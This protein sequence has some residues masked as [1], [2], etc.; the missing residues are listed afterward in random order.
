MREVDRLMTEELGVPLER[1]FLLG[2]DAGGRRIIMV[3]AGPGGNGAGGLVAARH[4][5][6]AGAEVEVRLAAPLERFAPVTADQA[7]VVQRLGL[8][9][10][11]G[12][13]SL[14]REPELVIDAL[15]GYSQAGAP[16]GDAARLIE[17][18]AG[19]RVLALD[20][21]SGLELATG[22]LQEPHVR[23]ETTLT[24]AAPKERLRAA[25]TREV[26]GQLFLADIS[27]PATIFEQ[28]GL[29]YQS[30]FG[31]SPIVLVESTG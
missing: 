11:D 27:V 21:P 16:Y 4:L 18:A 1:M 8:L 26:V 5:C 17:L 2:G 14:D 3:L 30:P 29:A 12:T 7:A 22:S 19:R 31:R 9:A 20:V 6:V 25:G 24:L 10:R 23:A 28:L 15:L 13:G